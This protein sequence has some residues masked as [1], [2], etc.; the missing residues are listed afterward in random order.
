LKLRYARVALRDIEAI[1]TYV[2][3][4]RVRHAILKTFQILTG[5]PFLG[6]PGRRKG[7]REKTVPRLPY[8]ILYR[9]GED[10]TRNSARVS[11]RPAGARLSRGRPVTRFPI[12]SRTG[13]QPA[14]RDI[15]TEF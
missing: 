6:R 13:S 8:L 11:W 14:V 15:R 3:A 12:R 1:R 2:A 4:E 10:E 7:T 5:F 9:T